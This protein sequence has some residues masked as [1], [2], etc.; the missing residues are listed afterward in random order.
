MLI[1]PRLTNNRTAK[2]YIHWLGILL[3]IPWN[4]FANE[5]GNHDGIDSELVAKRIALISTFRQMSPVTAD[6]QKGIMEA[7]RKN[8]DGP[9]EFEIEY[10][11]LI[12]NDD[13]K[14]L[15]GWIDL[16]STKYD[17]K[18]ADVIVPLYFPSLTFLITNRTSVFKNVPIVFCSVPGSFARFVAEKF[19]ITGVGFEFDFDGT[20]RLIEKLRPETRRIVYLCGVSEQD[21]YLRNVAM[22]EQRKTKRKFTVDYWEGLTIPEVRKK[23]SEL[24]N[25]TSVIV[26]S[27]DKDRLGNHYTTYEFVQGVADASAAP[28][29][30][31]YDTLLGSGVVGGSMVSPY[32]QGSLAGEIIALHLQGASIED[33]PVRHQDAPRVAFDIQLLKKYN[34]RTT[35]LP[36]GTELLNR[37]P[38]LWEQYGRYVATIIAVLV[39]QSLIIVSLLVNRTKRLNAEKEARMLAGKILSSIE[40]ERRYLARELHDDVSQRLAATAIATGNLENKTPDNDQL[41]PALM[42]L[43]QQLISICDDLHHMSHRMHPSSLDDIGLPE[44]LR[45]ECLSLGERSGVTIEYSVQEPLDP[46]PNDA[47]LCLYRVAQESLW[48]SAKHSGSK[49]VSVRLYSD[50]EFAYL[51]IVDDGCGFDLTSEKISSGL[52]LASMKERMRL[53]AGH[54]KLQTSPGNG[55]AVQAIVP[56]ASTNS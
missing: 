9:V 20:Y 27:M 55:V 52:G 43:K 8:Y 19:K 11:D 3:I 34:L 50:S 45:S 40:D 13:P 31:L 24:P 21:I 26:L 46:I 14:Y 48:N 25:D 42:K 22:T 51:D 54:L 15:K 39:L 37:Q 29:Y 18:P 36:A 7:I 6:W 38:T 53:V 32:R 2:L 16:L 33:I 44:A 49:K 4:L 35:N 47:S 56:I 17:E 5:N 23:L 12:H 1:H 41:K 30:S 10:L 28:I